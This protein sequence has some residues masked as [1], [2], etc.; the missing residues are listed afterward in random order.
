M[1][2]SEKMSFPENS[3]KFLWL[4]R[5]VLENFSHTTSVLFCC[6]KGQHLFSCDIFKAFSGCVEV[7]NG[8][9]IF[10]L[11]CGSGMLLLSE[12]GP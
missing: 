1:N 10:C 9:C 5:S 3:G 6:C 7:L 4:F 11:E 8:Y 12:I 2:L